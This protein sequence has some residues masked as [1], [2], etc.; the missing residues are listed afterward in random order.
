MHFGFCINCSL[1]PKAG[2]WIVLVRYLSTTSRSSDSGDRYWPELL[3]KYSG[4]IYFMLPGR[5]DDLLFFHYLSPFCFLLIEF[6]YT[7]LHF[8]KYY[9]IM[10]VIIVFRLGS[11]KLFCF[12]V[13]FFLFS[14]KGSVTGCDWSFR[15]FYYSRI[16]RHF[17][18][19]HLLSGYYY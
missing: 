13:G 10:F 3:L 4:W 7:F 16:I 18:F 9:N 11:D 17:A 14:H 1:S 8:L 5:V 6:H 2:K 12:F 15:S 19:M